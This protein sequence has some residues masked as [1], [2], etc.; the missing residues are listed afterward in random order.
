MKIEVR[1][2]DSG[3]WVKLGVGLAVVPIWLL[4]EVREHWSGKVAD[5]VKRGDAV[6]NVGL[7]GE[8]WAGW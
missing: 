6:V 8:G 3:V 4:D 2:M 5:A 7:D 1:R